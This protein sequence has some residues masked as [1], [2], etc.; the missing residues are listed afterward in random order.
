MNSNR[1]KRNV[2]SVVSS[3]WLIGVVLVLPPGD[4]V[5][6]NASIESNIHEALI[7]VAPLDLNFDSD[8]FADFLRSYHEAGAPPP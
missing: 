1:H 7:E 6:A 2:R 8:G 5:P 3:V 4:V